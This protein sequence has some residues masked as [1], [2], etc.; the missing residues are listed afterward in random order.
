MNT[1]VCVYSVSLQVLT[2]ARTRIFKIRSLLVLQ[3]LNVRLLKSP[4]QTLPWPSQSPLPKASKF[5]GTPL[6]SPP[7]RHERHH[8]TV[9]MLCQPPTRRAS[10]LSDFEGHTGS[11]SHREC[12]VRINACSGRKNPLSPLLTIHL[13]SSSTDRHNA[14]PLSSPGSLR[15]VS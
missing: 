15:D 14:Y 10:E 2:P 4:A 6:T 5:S 13:F 12:T 1:L 8:D 9:R 7:S 3:P 11:T